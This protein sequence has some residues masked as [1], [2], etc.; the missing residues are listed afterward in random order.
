MSE[1]ISNELPVITSIDELPETAIEELTGGI[2]PEV[3]AE[4]PA[5]KAAA[6]PK[7]AKKSEDVVEAPVPETTE[8]PTQEKIES[9]EVVEVK[10]KRK[11]RTKA[12]MEAARA[13]E[14]AAKEE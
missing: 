3:V 11:R 1:N 12:E 6:K 8:D 10:P 14:K 5:T 2:E 4:K 13:A 9:V 7:K